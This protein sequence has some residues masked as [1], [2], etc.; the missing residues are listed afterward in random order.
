MAGGECASAGRFAGVVVWRI[1]GVH[2]L[3]LCA[4]A[5]FAFGLEGWRHEPY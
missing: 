3:K 1:M 4:W 2:A 5:E